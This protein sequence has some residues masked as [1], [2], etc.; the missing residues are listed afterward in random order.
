MYKTGLRV[1]RRGIK[2]KEKRDKELRRKRDKEA[3]EKED[4][5]GGELQYSREE[6]DISIHCRVTKKENE[7]SLNKQL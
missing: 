3:S 7:Q 6:G 5:S 2:R 4:K 1:R